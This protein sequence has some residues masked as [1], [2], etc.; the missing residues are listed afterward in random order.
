MRTT[1]SLATALALLAL[2]TLLAPSR[3]AATGGWT[4]RTGAEYGQA[5]TWAVGSGA[6]TT[7]PR[8]DLDLGL[9]AAGA[10]V[11]PGVVD[12]G[13]A[14]QY[15][16]TAVDGN[17]S[18]QDRLSYGLNTTL[19]GSAGSPLSLS[20][21]ATRHDDSFSTEG[22]AAGSLLGVSYGGGF[23]VRGSASR[24]VLA[25]QYS[26]THDDSNT[27]ALGQ[28][29][30]ALQTVAAQTGFGASTF[31][32]NASYSGAFSDGSFET[33]KYADHRIE[34]NADAGVATD[35]RLR[36]SNVFYR[37]DTSALTALNA[38]Q[39][40]DATS[41]SV[42][43]APPDGHG[44]QHV[45]SYSYSR[46][47]QR[48]TAQDVE[49]LA[50]QVSYSLAG[51][52]PAP[53]WSLRGTASANVDETRLNAVVSR[54]QGQ[55]LAG[56]LTWR[57]SVERSVVELH[58]GPLVGVLEPESGPARLGYGASTGVVHSRNASVRTSLSY[59]VAFNHDVGVDQGSS[60]IQTAAGSAD[61]RAGLATLHGSLQLGADRRQSPLFGA[62]GSRSVTGTAAWRMRTTA[63]SAQLGYQD[64]TSGRVGSIG[65][66]GLFIA[67]AYD[68]R[69]AYAHLGAGTTLGRFVTNARIRFSSTDLP[70]R[71]RYSETQLYASVDYAYG[72]LRIGL[73]DTY[74]VTDVYGGRFRTNQFL[75]RAYRI[76]G[77]RF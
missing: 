72:A 57:R 65:G 21:F 36:L 71:P 27:V 15:R 2:L 3:A 20:G 61:M 17:A 49:R 32:Y 59:D 74:V 47:M 64:G 7:T 48:T 16:R 73:E 34:L 68:S 56:V 18:V 38:R 35:T 39:E 6:K 26:Y 23:N 28:T 25:G 54:S 9:N 50:H 1:L 58:G 55:S 30:R 29:S 76:F 31:S 37:R 52:L 75:V 11:G 40:S 69:T 67:P 8:L 60:L 14:S 45:G 63:V 53:E 24:P 19:F 62:T 10:L 13:L 4:L 51:R 41:A 46:A 42:I 33:D 22:A 12:W 66:D 77:S 43:N 44:L 5:D 70:D